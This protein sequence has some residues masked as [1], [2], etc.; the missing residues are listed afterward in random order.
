MMTSSAISQY[1]PKASPFANRR[2]RGLS[3]DDN[4]AIAVSPSTTMDPD[5]PRLPHRVLVTGASGFVGRH[6]I[7]YLAE[8]GCHVTAA[9]RTPLRIIHPKISHLELPDLTQPTNWQPL[10]AGCDAVVHLAGIAHRVVTD[11]TYDTANH[12]ATAALAESTRA[13]GA[14]LLFVSSIAAQSGA[15]SSRELSENDAPRP[16]NAYGRSK[17]A[18]EAAIRASGA[19]FTI[20]RPVVMYGDGEKGNFAA[21]HKIARLPIPLPFGALHA[22]RSVLSIENFNSAIRAVLGSP[23]MKGE[24]FIVADPEPVS[25]TELIAQARAEARKPRWLVPVPDG[26]LRLAL[27]SCGRGQLWDKIGA[28]LV[29]K[30]QKLMA[31]GWVPDNQGA[32]WRAQG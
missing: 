6:L 22:K 11:E 23:S 18:A 17:L 15:S 16:V 25:V 21:I 12:R 14:H 28:P 32:L 20:L 26:W 5:M 31:A 9:S 29:A 3:F 30:P 1:Q 10:V 2:P 4:S 8:S 27:R 24:T 7:K 19:S 13:C